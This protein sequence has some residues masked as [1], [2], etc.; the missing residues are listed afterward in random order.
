MAGG[1]CRVVDSS[2]GDI[3]GGLGDGRSDGGVVV[4]ASL[5]WLVVVSSGASLEDG[6]IEGL[7]FRG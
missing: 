2:M 5:A 1:A 6:D 4:V 7:L 3:D